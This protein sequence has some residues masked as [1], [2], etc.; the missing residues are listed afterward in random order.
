G[1]DARKIQTICDRLQANL[2]ISTFYTSPLNTPSLLFLASEFQE[3]NSNL[4][5]DLEKHYAMLSASRI[6]A[7]SSD[8]A[9]NL[10]G[11]YPKITLEKIDTI[12]I[13]EVNQK[14][15]EEISNFL[16]YALSERNESSQH[17]VWLEL[18]KLQ[19]AQQTIYLKQQQDY[20]TMQEMEISLRELENNHNY[21]QKN[22]QELQEQI[23]YLSSRK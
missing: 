15:A 12:E 1:K 7:F 9:Q 10:R 19:E 4:P 23:N 17:Q 14:L 21:L 3:E 2:F 11:L 20:H 6:I 22:N 8:I 16:W 18:R 13:A 5:V